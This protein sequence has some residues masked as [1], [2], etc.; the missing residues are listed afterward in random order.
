MARQDKWDRDNSRR[1]FY[2]VQKTVNVHGV[3]Q[4]EG[5]SFNKTKV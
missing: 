5:N 1:K 3:K 4:K 2:S